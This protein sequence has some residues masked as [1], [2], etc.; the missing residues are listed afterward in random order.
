MRVFS[1]QGFEEGAPCYEEVISIR[2]WVL[3][4]FSGLAL[5]GVW[6]ARDRVKSESLGKGR[7]RCCET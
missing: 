6:G 5:S 2:G 7:G 1:A 4:T 3:R